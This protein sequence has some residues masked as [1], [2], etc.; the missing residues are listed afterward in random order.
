[1]AGDGFVK[2]PN[3]LPESLSA[4]A[5]QLWIFVRRATGERLEPCWASREKLDTW[6]RRGKAASHVS[7]RLRSALRELEQEGLLA[8]KRRGPGQSALRWALW[9]GAKGDSELRQLFDGNQIP[10]NLYQ[11]VLLARR[12]ASVLSER[13]RE[14][15]AIPRDRVPRSRLPGRQR[16]TKQNQLNK[17]LETGRVST[18]STGKANDTSQRIGSAEREPNLSHDNKRTEQEQTTRKQAPDSFH[19][20]WTAELGGERGQG[21]A[22]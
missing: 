22:R 4:V 11:E 5:L 1:M 8:V 17:T 9:P 3:A 6:M 13:S 7:S 2:V 21:D 19:A 20:Q 15:E 10:Q 14:D 16:P 12:D 18:L